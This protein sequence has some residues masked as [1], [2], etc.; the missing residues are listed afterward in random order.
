MKADVVIGVPD[1][2]LDAIS[3]PPVSAADIRPK[4]LK[5]V[6]KTVLKKKFMDKTIPKHSDKW[7]KSY[8][9]L[10]NCWYQLGR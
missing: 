2:G 8:V 9:K 6:K 5:T 3:A 4:F 7:R 10:R 1:S